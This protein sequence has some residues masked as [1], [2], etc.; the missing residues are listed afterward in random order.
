L[1]KQL[2]YMQIITSRFPL[3]QWILGSASKRITTDSVEK[4]K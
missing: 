3:N 1:L 2:I 4:R